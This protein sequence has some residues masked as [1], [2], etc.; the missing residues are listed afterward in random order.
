MLLAAHAQRHERVRAAGDA[1]AVGPGAGPP[2]L[3]REDGPGAGAR[4]GGGRAGG[5][6]DGTILPDGEIRTP[7]VRASREP[8]VRTP[9]ILLAHSSI[10]R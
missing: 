6:H 4:E 2:V 5:G 1:L 10:T 7:A 8:P 9:D 3:G